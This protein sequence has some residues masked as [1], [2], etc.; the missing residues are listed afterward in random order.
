LLHLGVGY[1]H[2]RSDPQ[3]PRFDNSQIGFKGTNADIFPY[4]SVLSVAQGGMA[5]FGPPSNFRIQNLK[6][7]GNVSLTRVRNNHTYKAGGELIVNGYPSFSETYSSGNMLFS[8]TQTGLPALQG[9]SL[10]ASVGF[11]YASGIPFRTPTATTNLNALIFR[12]TLA[13]RVPGEPLFTTTWVDKKGNLQR[14]KN[15]NCGCYDPRR[16]FILNPRGWRNPPDGKFSTS[17]AR[18][19]DYRQQRRPSESMSLGRRFRMGEESV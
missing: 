9:V 14:T 17:N 5:N 12:G 13:E 6:P 15:W 7:T 16:T 8:P 2:I 1:V 19:S 10:P 11:N 3:V 4:F 18:Y